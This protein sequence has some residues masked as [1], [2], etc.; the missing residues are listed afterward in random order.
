L[1]Y[2][3]TV[4]TL[5]FKIK[6]FLKGIGVWGAGLQIAGEDDPAEVI[7]HSVG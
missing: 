4:K 2:Q 5:N 3:D 7:R 1:F 6:L